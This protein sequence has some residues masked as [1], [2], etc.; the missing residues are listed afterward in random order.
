MGRRYLPLDM[1]PLAIGRELRML[2]EAEGILKSRIS[3]LEAQ[4]ENMLR[5]GTHVPF[6]AMQSTPGRLGWNRPA[7]EIFM[8]GDMLGKNLRS[9]PEPITPTQA[10]KAGMPADLVNAYAT[11]SSGIKLVPD[12]GT[13][14]RLTFSSSDT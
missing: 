2:K 1:S 7:V 5:A 14:A 12:D 9:D 10:I 4:T 13:D 8:L 3:G 6:W 11:R